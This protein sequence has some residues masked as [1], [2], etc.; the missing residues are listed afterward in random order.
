MEDNFKKRI[1]VTKP[2]LPDLDELI[3]Y[4]RD[5]WS[6]GWLTNEGKYHRQFEHDLSKFLRVRY[7]SLFSNGTQALITALQA[8]RITGEVITT[9]YSFVAT[10]HSLWWNNIK[11][12]FVDI[13]PEFCNLDPEKIEAAI[14]PQTTAIL[15]VHVYGNPCKVER[16][17]D[18]ADIY[19]LKVIYDSAHAFGVKYKGQS[20]LE[21]G[22][23][24]VLSFHATKV[25]T[26]CEGGAIVCHDEKTKKRL[27]YLRNFG[28]AGETKV[29]AHGINSKMNEMQAALG[30]LQLKYHNQNIEKR[31]VISEIYRRELK[32][33]KGLFFLP[34][35][36]DTQS[37]YAYFPIFVDKGYG[38]HRDKLYEKLKTHGIYGRRYFYPLISNFPTY[39]SLKSADKDNLPVANDI[40]KKVICLPIYPGLNEEKVISITRL[41]KNGL[42]V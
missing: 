25:F 18:I 9:P 22:D 32:D 39:R 37:N 31:K 35:P 13:E 16:I 7:I 33:I 1:F 11:P 3:P 8:M 6:S 24:S 17:Q 28:F 26:T 36:A 20:I 21:Y 15:P 12:V 10:T 27:G 4:L 2:S 41:I 30:L 14:T 42:N 38:I 23:L 5:I 29:I 19:G 34:E 40:A